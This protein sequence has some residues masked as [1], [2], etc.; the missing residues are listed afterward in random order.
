MC[1]SEH[2]ILKIPIFNRCCIHEVNIRMEDFLNFCVCPGLNTYEMVSN[3]D[4][5]WPPLSMDL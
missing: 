2:A 3:Q 5:I 1:G 4:I